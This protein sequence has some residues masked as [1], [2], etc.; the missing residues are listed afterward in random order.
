[1]KMER[2]NRNI[3][4]R[5]NFFRSSL[6]HVPGRCLNKWAGYFEDFVFRELDFVFRAYW[7]A[8]GP[9]ATNP[10]LTH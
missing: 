1:M 7:T 4:D 5:H 2:K 10:I 3:G 8:R 6:A 9:N